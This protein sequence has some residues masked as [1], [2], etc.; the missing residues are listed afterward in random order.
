MVGLVVLG[1]SSAAGEGMKGVLVYLVLC[2]IA[3]L[4]FFSCVALARGEEPVEKIDELAGLFQTQPIM[5]IA[6]A[7][8]LFSMAG[9]PPLAG[10]FGKY[11]VLL[12]AIQGGLLWLAVIGVFTSVVAAA[13]YLRVI[14][15]MFFDAPKGLPLVLISGRI[16]Q[17][18][19]MVILWLWLVLFFI[20]RLCLSRCGWQQKVC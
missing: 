7:V 13:Y 15:V 17:V 20:P 5:A 2:V 10:F 18:V 6:L 11:F 9:I 3:A 16:P 14:K 19:V 12:S 4:G 8:C 1:D